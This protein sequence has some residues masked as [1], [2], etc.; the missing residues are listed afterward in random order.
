MSK[1]KGQSAKVVEKKLASFEQDKGGALVALPA[2]IATGESRTLKEYWDRQIALKNHVSA[3]SS[4]S[5]ISQCIADLIA[6]CKANGL[7]AVDCSGNWTLAESIQMPSKFTLFGDG[8]DGAQFELT[9]VNA[10]VIVSDNYLSANGK[11]PTGRAFLK[12][13]TVIGDPLQGDNHGFLIRDYYSELI[14]CKSYATGGDGFKL[15]HKNDIAE[16]T[17]NLVENRLVRCQAINPKKS[18]F[19][20]GEQDNNRL[21]DGYLIECI[22]DQDVGAGDQYYH[23]RI[24]SAAGWTINGFH[25]YGAAMKTSMEISNGYHTNISNVYLEAFKDYGLKLLR[26]QLGVNVA[27][28]GAKAAGSGTGALATGNVIFADKSSLVNETQVNVANLIVHQDA[29]AAVNALNTAS[30]ATIINASNVAATGA[31]RSRVNKVASGAS[32]KLVQDAE[33]ERPLTE[34]ASKTTLKHAGRPLA[35]YAKS[36]RLSGNDAKTITLPVVDV[37]NF[38][39]VTGL[40]TIH[41]N[42]FDNGPKRAEYVAAVTLSAKTNG[43]DAWTVIVSEIVTPFGFTAAPVVS[44]SNTGGD[45]GTLNIEFTWA[46]ADATGTVAFVSNTNDMD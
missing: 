36:A 40:L 45:D 22:A 3:S 34:T 5:T 24:G 28:I 11:S 42:S 29:D 46:D 2:I 6:Y 7:Y 44:A 4:S 18:S 12:K 14:G 43:T 19:D 35:K 25:A 17:G 33:I 10:P 1:A 31:F 38:G 32:V 39:K 37:P 13:I 8:E 15:T 21:T 9:G 20:L 30:A 41:A 16:V 26:T 27:N 23:A